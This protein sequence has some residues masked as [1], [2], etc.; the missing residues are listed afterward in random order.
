MGQSAYM[1]IMKKLI[2]ICLLWL[3]ACAAT[4]TSIAKRNLDVQ[5]KMTDSIFLEPVAPIRRTVFVD[6]K[7]T[8]DKPDFDIER[9]VIEAITRNGYQVIDDPARAQ[10]MLQANILQAGRSSETAAERAYNEGFGS[11]LT[12]GAAGAGVGYG[13]G[14]AGGNDA[15][16]TAGGAV[17]GATVAT[18][19][20]AFVQDVT[21]SVVTDI[22]VSERTQGGSTVTQSENRKNSQGSSGS[23]TET[24]TQTTDWKRYRTRVVAKANKV[25]LEWPEAAPFMV[26]GL[27]RSISGIF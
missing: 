23:V 19:A 9:S 11:V 17:I 2:S 3:T 22:Q 4:E 8:S 14:K 7:N 26:D 25:N 20:D 15:L 21:Y 24:S 12:G 13:L 10:F 16:L 6:V 18:I 1:R 5:T 27:T